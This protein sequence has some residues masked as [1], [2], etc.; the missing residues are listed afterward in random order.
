MDRTRKNTWLKRQR[1]CALFEA[2]RS[3]LAG[4]SFTSQRE[5][6]DY[7]RMQPAPRF[8]ISAHAAAS[9]INAILSGREIKGLNSSS[10]RRLDE[11]MRR[12]TAIRENPKFSGSSVYSLCQR[13]V[14]E[15]AP[16]FYVGYE[17]ASKVICRETMMHNE[18]VAR[19]RRMI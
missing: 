1:D 19:R 7:V 16:E 9:Y 13:I 4:R 11:L 6:V 2:Y 5:A 15:P 18:R 14:E 3:A 17:L 8:Y 10:R 12:F